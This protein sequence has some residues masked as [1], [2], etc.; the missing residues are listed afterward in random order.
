MKAIPIPRR[1]AAMLTLVCCATLLLAQSTKPRIIVLTD[2]E[3]D[4]RC[5]M[6]H[7]L[8]CADCVDIAGLIQTS[9]CFQTHGHS[10]EHW[11][12]AQ[13]DH[14]AEVY[15]NLKVHSDGYPTPDALRAVALVGDED[16]A[17][18]LADNAAPARVPGMPSAMDPTDWPDTPGSDLIVKVLLD[19][20]PRP[21]HIQAWGGGNTAAKAFQKI[22][23]QYPDQYDRAM[24]KVVMYNSWYQDA[25]GSYIE[26]N[27]PGVTM[28]LSHFFSGTWDYNSQLYTDE[29]VTRYLHNDHG[30]LCADYVQDFISEG[31]S[32]SFF[33]SL[34]NGLR[35]D[36]D[37]TYGGWGGLFYKVDGFDRVYRDV[38]KGSYTQWTEYILRDFQMRAQW[39]VAPTYD[40]ANHA[41]VLSIDGLDRTVHSGERVLIH[42]DAHDTDKPDVDYLWNIN[43]ELY[44]QAGLTKEMFAEHI[45]QI[46]RPLS[47]RWWQYDEAG[48]YPQHITLVQERSDEAWFIAPEVSEPQ[49]IH[50]IC[51]VTDNGSPR[52]TSFARVIVTVL[53][54]E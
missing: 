21:V 22:K 45:D 6:V 51:E 26:Q 37:P 33:Y 39:C 48:T 47:F 23:D 30:P 7:L 8:L 53:P 20:D 10:Q 2:S 14:Y 32:P 27:H 31:D 28:L 36:E 34:A 16:P 52:M 42:A 54:R 24:A 43:K 41:P 11:L 15:P 25:A 13:L 29:F 44:T 49:T 18:V 12:E 19:D 5:S 40:E 4:D 1:L 3:V 50:V 35:S 9:S 17:H 38:S 46:I